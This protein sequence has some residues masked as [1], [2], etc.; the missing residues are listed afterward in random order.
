MRDPHSHKGENGK[1]IVIGGSKTIHGAP[2][3]SMLA[4]EASGADLIFGFVPACHAAIARSYSLNF[5]ITPFKGDELSKS[6]RGPI[7]ELLATMDA[8]VLGPGIARDEATLKVLREI[9]SEAPCPLVLDASALQPWTLDVVSGKQAILTPHLGELERMDIAEKMIGPAAKKHNV[10]IHV[11][12]PVDRIASPDG[13]VTEVSGGNAGLTVG[14]TGDALAGLIA[15]LLSQERSPLEA[16]VTASTVIK[17]AGAVLMPEFGYAYGTR[18][19]IDLIPNILRAM[20]NDQ[21][22]MTRQ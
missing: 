1:V 4:A 10:T 22:P 20:N 3:F 18:R 21:A 15:G 7:L 9:I 16:S 12:G 5:Q 2:I 14:G 19:V 6:D 11:K 17:R 13:S 8:A